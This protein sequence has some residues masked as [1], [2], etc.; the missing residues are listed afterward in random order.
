MI[1]VAGCAG[2]TEEVVVETE[3]EEQEV[4]DHN[5][6]TEQDI[7]VEN[8]SNEGADQL[9]ETFEAGELREKSIHLEERFFQ[10]GNSGDLEADFPYEFLEGTGEVNVL[11]STPH[12]TTHIREQEVR[13]AE[14]YTGAMAL[15]IQEYTGAHIIYNTYEGEDANHVLGGPYKEKIGD[16]IDQHE[17]ELVIDLHGASRNRSFDV[18]IGT[19]YGETVRDEWVAEL[20]AILTHHEILRV[21]ENDSFPATHE[22]TVTQH[23]WSHYDTE[24]MQLEINM[25][26]RQARHNNEPFYRLLQSLITFVENVD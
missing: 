22:G 19:N 2:E 11:I 15:L 3:E 8:F 21:Y 25:D 17:I 14:I 4:E 20:T 7:I 6:E 16:I 24:A 18:D 10:N 23:T 5:E 12:T 13:P 1:L 26:Y 9:T